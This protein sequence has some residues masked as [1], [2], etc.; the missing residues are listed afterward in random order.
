MSC[1]RGY[2]KAFSSAAL[3]LHAFSDRPALLIYD[4]A[5]NHRLQIR[6]GYLVD[7]GLGAM[8]ATETVPIWP[9]PAPTIA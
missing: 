6:I 8:E 7:G 4:D 3:T 5:A 1:S 9:A 2:F